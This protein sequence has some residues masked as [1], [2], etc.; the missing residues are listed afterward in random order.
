[1]RLPHAEGFTCLIKVTEILT[2]EVACLGFESKVLKST[3]DCSVTMWTVLHFS[4]P[5][6]LS[7]YND[8][9]SETIVMRLKEKLF[10]KETLD[11]WP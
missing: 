1:M 4:E 6:F 7:Q 11:D 8:S 9:H 3:C 5:W 2:S 10:V